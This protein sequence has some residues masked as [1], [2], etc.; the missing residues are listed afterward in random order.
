MKRFLSN[1]YLPAELPP[2]FNSESFSLYLVANAP[3]QAPFSLSKSDPPKYV[4]QPETYNLA[5]A[6]TLRRNLSLPNPVNFYQQAKIFTDAWDT[7]KKHYSKSQTSLSTP[8]RTPAG[9]KTRAYQWLKPFSELQTIRLNTRF[10]KRYLVKTDIKSCYPSI[11]THSI[12][13]A[14][15]GKAKSQANTEFSNSLGNKI[16]RVIQNSQLKQTKGIQ[17]GPDSSYLAAE[18]ILTRV[19]QFIAKRLGKSYLRF[20]DDFEFCSDSYNAAEKALSVFQEAL[21][22]YGLL[23]NESKTS[24]AE[25]PAPIDDAWTRQLRS[26]RIESAIKPKTQRAT[27]IDL[28]DTSLALRQQFPDQAVVKYAIAMTSS[29][30]IDSS[31]WALYQQILLQWAQVEPQVLPIALDLL[32]A[33]KGADFVI[34]KNLLASIL[35]LIINI[36]S[37]RG[38]TSEVAWSIWGH[39][40]F[41]IPVDPSA[42]RNASRLNSSVVALL[43]LDARAKGLIA[44]SEKFSRWLPLMQPNSLATENWLLAYEARVK[45]WLPPVGTKEYIKTVA[46]FG[47]LGSNGVSFYD[48]NLSKNYSPDLKLLKIRLAL[49]QDYAY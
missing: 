23:A 11:Y 6:G 34:E 26:T 4:S 18:I 44:K 7:L 17:I 49:T 32:A 29:T 20:M 9:L 19:D 10:G 25:L 2:P 1:G 43:M 8:T 28:F 27:L 21:A 40:L 5:R 16:D 33:Y 47:L 35:C 12:A 38:H 46:G 22:E 31:N 39:L 14:L 13:W 48:E 37:S 15:H 3:S 24:I 41:A 36:H 42:V 45:K 30:V